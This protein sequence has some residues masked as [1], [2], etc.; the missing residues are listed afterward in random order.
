VVFPKTTFYSNEWVVNPVWV[1][2]IVGIE[3]QVI[4]SYKQAKKATEYLIIDLK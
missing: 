4:L 1:E 3:S 2:L